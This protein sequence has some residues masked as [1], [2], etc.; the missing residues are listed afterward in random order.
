MRVIR[1]LNEI[2]VPLKGAVVTIGNF[3]GIHLGHREI[4]RNVVAKAKEIN[5]TS[6]VYTFVP[7][8]LKVL[9]PDRALRLINTYTEKERLIEASCIDVLICAPFTQEMAGL[10]ASSF[11][12]DVLVKRLGVVHLVVGYDYAFGRNREGV[13][14]SYS[15]HYTKLYEREKN[16]DYTGKELFN[17][18]LMYFAN[19]EDQGMLIFP[20]HRL[21]HNLQGF[22]LSTFLDSLGIYFDVEKEAIEP[23]DPEARKKAARVLQEKGNS[24]NFV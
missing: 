16:P 8:P 2:T 11:V 23:S 1:N 15:I 14:T 10:T 19:M 21:L 3:D 9:A 24:Y 12:E 13:I 22:N 20:T 18:V 4:F 5:G 17:Y 6:V 7:H